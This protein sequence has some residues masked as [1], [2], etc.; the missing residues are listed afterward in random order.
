MRKRGFTL[1]ELMIVVAVIAIVAAIAV[2][3]LLRARMSANEA[4]AIASCKAY[5]AAQEIYRRTDWD[6]D[7]V[8]EYARQTVGPASLAETNWGRWDICL[9]DK[10]LANAFTAPVA[11]SRMK[12]GYVFQIQPGQGPAASGGARSYIRGGNMT[13]GYG[14]SAVPISYDSTGRNAFQLNHTGVLRQ[15][16]RGAVFIWHENLF[17]P[18]STWAVVE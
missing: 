11:S 18:N 16:D 14:I 8:M 10:E 12:D 3:N 7:A 13:L 17:N 15:K 6:K 4:G 5:A 2:P 9:I 1:I